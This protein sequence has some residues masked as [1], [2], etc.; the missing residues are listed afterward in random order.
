[1]MDN[2]DLFN[3]TSRNLLLINNYF[4]RQLPLGMAPRINP[5]LFL[6]AFSMKVDDTRV[7]AQDWAFAPTGYTRTV[8]KGQPD[9]LLTESDKEFIDKLK[10]GL[11]EVLEQ[12]EC[13]AKFVPDLVGREVRPFQRSTQSYVGRSSQ[14]SRSFSLPHLFFAC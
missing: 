6:S 10:Q 9:P 11:H 13:G 2:E 5:T 1:M 14:K 3:Y 7:T 8:S 12:E 4:L